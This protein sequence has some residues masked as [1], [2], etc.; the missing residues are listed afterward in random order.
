MALHKTAGRWLQDDLRKTAADL[1]RDAARL[2]ELAARLEATAFDDPAL[3]V[4]ATEISGLS[5]AVA[6]K[7]RAGVEL[8]GPAD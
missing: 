2:D 4:L 7:A 6:T 5:A 3:V 1:D 8:A